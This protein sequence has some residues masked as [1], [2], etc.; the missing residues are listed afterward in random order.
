MYTKEVT[1]LAVEDLRHLT[2]VEMFGI[3]SMEACVHPSLRDCLFSLINFHVV[4]CDP[5]CK[6]V[7]MCN[8]DYEVEFLPDHDEGINIIFYAKRGLHFLD[9]FGDVT[10]MIIRG[11]TIDEILDNLEHFE[12]YAKNE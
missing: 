5:D 10:T 2:N 12:E 3:I 8:D 9:T 6:S 7:T 4:R 1:I 11:W